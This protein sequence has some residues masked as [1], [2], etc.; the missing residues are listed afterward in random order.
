MAYMKH[1][2]QLILAAAVVSASV[3][4]ACWVRPCGSRVEIYSLGGSYC[5]S[6]SCGEVAEAQSD[7]NI[8]AVLLTNGRVEL[9]GTNG[10]YKASLSVSDGR[11]IQVCN[12]RVAV[13]RSGGRME[14][15][16]ANGS[17]CGSF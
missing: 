6:I 9:Y 11:H 10:S 14:I 8:I 1:F 3:A 15:Y 5:G 7:G 17:Y 12:G 16:N 4:E 13:T 2:V